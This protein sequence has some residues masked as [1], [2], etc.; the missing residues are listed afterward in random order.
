MPSPIDDLASLRGAATPASPWSL[1]A[2]ERHS[3]PPQTRSKYANMW[4][5]LGAEPHMIRVNTWDVIPPFHERAEQGLV[6]QAGLAGEAYA[7]HS[8]VQPGPGRPPVFVHTLSN[9]GYLAYGGMVGRLAWAAGFPVTHVTHPRDRFSQRQLQGLAAFQRI[10]SPTRGI[11]VDSAPSAL[12]P[13]VWIRWVWMGSACRVWASGR[14]G[15]A[16]IH[17][18]FSTAPGG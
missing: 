17:T 16:G 15:D 7:A 6:Q 5:V 18:C 13:D 3:F 12:T 9:A 2:A 10:M 8:A 11:I 4:R 14:G 1:C